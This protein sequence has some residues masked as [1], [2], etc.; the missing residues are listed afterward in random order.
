[1]MT[2][3]EFRNKYNDTERIVSLENIK[4]GCGT[5]SLEIDIFR[6]ND[7]YVKVTYERVVKK[8]IKPATYPSDDVYIFI[9]ESVIPIIEPG[10]IVKWHTGEK[11]FEEVIHYNEYDDGTTE[12]KVI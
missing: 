2:K 12:V 11:L 3:E 7:E 6:C 10:V 5:Y 4:G 9:V 8:A 1:M